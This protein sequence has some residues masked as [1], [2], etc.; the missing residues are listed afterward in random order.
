LTFLGPNCAQLGKI[1]SNGSCFVVPLNQ[2]VQGSSPCAPTI[3]FNDL[4]E[5]DFFVPTPLLSC[6]SDKST[7]FVR[8]D[9]QRRNCSDGDLHDRLRLGRSPPWGRIGS[10]EM[11]GYFNSVAQAREIRTELRPR[12][13][14]KVSQRCLGR[15]L[16]APTAYLNE[17]DV[18]FTPKATKFVRQRNMS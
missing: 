4:G 9:L 15:Y 1:I 13:L 2:R 14:G 10:L 16:Q 7:A 5:M 17:G 11:P 3:N 18:R 6:H 12:D 8:A